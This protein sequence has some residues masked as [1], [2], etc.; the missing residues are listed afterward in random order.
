MKWDMLAA[1]HV[2]GMKQ[3]NKFF[4]LP[5]GNESLL[6]LFDDNGILWSSDDSGQTFISRQF[7]F[8]RVDY[9]DMFMEI[10]YD[11]IGGCLI[12]A[13]VDAQFQRRLHVFIT[14]DGGATWT[15]KLTLECESWHQFVARF[16]AYCF[17]E[18]YGYFN[19]GENNL[20]ITSN[21]FDTYFYTN[22]E[23]VILDEYAGDFARAK[24]SDPYDCVLMGRGLNKG[25]TEWSPII[26]ENGWWQG[27]CEINHQG[28]PYCYND[29]MTHCRDLNCIDGLGA[30][31]FIAS[32]DGIIYKSGMVPENGA[33]FPRG[34]EW[35][36]EIK[37][38]NGDVTFQHLEYT[39]DTAINSRRVKIITETNT[40]YDKTDWVDYEYIY[41][42]GDL[43]YWWNKELEEFTLLYDFGA[44]EGD[45]WII[46][47]GGYT[48]TV[49]V[50]AVQFVNYENQIY[51]I[52]S[53]S[54]QNHLFTGDIICG[55]GHQKSFFPEGPI[56]KDFEVEGLRCFWQDG[57]LLLTLGDEDCDAVYYGIHGL[58]ETPNTA[59]TIYPNPT[60]N[61]LV[62]TYITNSDI[63]SPSTPTPY[64]ITTLLGQTVKSGL[65]TSDNQQIDIHDLNQGFYF[66]TIGEI[67]QKIIIHHFQ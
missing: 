25:S 45:M 17:V 9:C 1:T 67:T 64:H 30:T 50:D 66:I 15:E 18:L 39:A 24:F 20:L 2:L 4:V 56:V 62:I 59:F 5:Y 57:E 41:E 10:G 52:L 19:N 14:M 16:D 42:E 34:I 60:S 29:G 40:M 13:D 44:V 54:D 58:N 35:Y 11:Y 31:F 7:D 55:I 65:I 37:H 26:I 32:E 36:Y 38:V 47:G 46:N 22:T 53:V 23:S 8:G 49:H 28:I 48:I 43:V 33:I 63:P 12:V 3:T 61:H 27:E 6:Y 51:K 21:G